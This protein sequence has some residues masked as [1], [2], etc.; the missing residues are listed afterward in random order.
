M[1]YEIEDRIFN[2]FPGYCRAV[3]VARDVDNGGEAPELLALL[4]DL[5][6]RVREDPGM[7]DYREHPNIA[8]WRD[9]FRSMD[10]NPNKYPPSIAN[11]IKRTRSGKDLPFINKLVTIFNVISLKYI[12]PCG[13]D[14]VDVLEGAI[15]LGYAK[16]NETYVPLGQPDNREIPPEGE[17]IYFDTGNLDVFCRGWCWK[18][19]D[20]SKITPLTR[21]VAIN[22]EAMPPLNEEKAMSMAAELAEMVQ[23]HCGGSTEIHLLT[24]RDPF[25]EIHL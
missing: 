20:R 17:V 18:N 22:I 2:A 7:E 13:G 21:N 10:L 19:G 12:T 11:L 6:R 16:G 23:K 24:E 1:R 14:D 4:R 15:R 25:F 3:V 5:E 8:A 9:T